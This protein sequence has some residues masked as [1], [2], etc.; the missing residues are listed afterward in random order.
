M[1]RILAPL[2]RHGHNGPWGSSWWGQL[3]RPRPFKELIPV[4]TS[5]QFLRHAAL[6]LVAFLGCLLSPTAASEA[7]EAVS[8]PKPNIV[9]LL[10]DDLG[11]GMCHDTR[12]VLLTDSAS[13]LPDSEV[14]LAAALKGQGYATAC[15]GKWHL[16]HLPPY[17]PTR[18]GFDSYYGIPYSN[19]MDRVA[20]RQLG[21]SIFFDPKIEYWNPPLARGD[22]IVERPANQPTLTKRYTEEAVSFIKANKS[23]PFFLYLAYNAPH[24][25]LFASEAFRGKSTR[26]LYGDVVEELDGSV[27]QVLDALRAEGLHERTLVVFTSDNGP[28]LIFDQLGGSAGLLR[29]G[30]GST[31]EGGMRVPGLFWWPGRIK[32]RTVTQEMAATLDI[33]PT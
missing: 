18:R 27:G 22:K 31:F 9:I 30:K 13:G 1:A 16:G 24:V 6:G 26:G 15:I 10:A 7:S 21:R 14:T 17:L 20:D 3:I 8:S 4:R 19:D 2:R 5:W 28:L 25:P 11:D 33:F 12:R 23:R 29:D 32:A